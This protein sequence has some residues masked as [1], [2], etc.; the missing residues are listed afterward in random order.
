MRYWFRQ[1][2][3]NANFTAS[4]AQLVYMVSGCGFWQRWAEHGTRVWVL[5]HK[6]K[7]QRLGIW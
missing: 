3:K 4:V 7:S 5:D 2:F 6:E 1:K